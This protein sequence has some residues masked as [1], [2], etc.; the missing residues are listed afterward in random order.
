MTTVKFSRNT[1]VTA[2][3]K[4]MELTGKSFKE[5]FKTIEKHIEIWK[6]NGNKMNFNEKY[7]YVLECARLID[8]EV[9]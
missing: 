5:S 3:L 7:S 4:V 2:T 6:D 9:A 8:K 1:P